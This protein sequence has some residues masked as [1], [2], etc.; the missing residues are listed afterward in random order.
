[1]LVRPQSV[2]SQSQDVPALV[3]CHFVDTEPRRLRLK[4]KKQ[5]KHVGS[6]FL[7]THAR[8]ECLNVAIMFRGYSSVGKS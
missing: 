8:M 7:G 6:G 4:T 3:R 5:N 2:V 1:M